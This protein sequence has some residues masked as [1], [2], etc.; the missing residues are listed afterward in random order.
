MDNAFQG[1]GQDRERTEEDL[2]GGPVSRG[3][4]NQSVSSNQAVDPTSTSSGD[5]AE[6]Y[7]RLINRDPSGTER[8]GSATSNRDLGSVGGGSIPG[9]NAYDGMNTSSSTAEGGSSSASAGSDRGNVPGM[10]ESPGASN[11]SGQPYQGTLGGRNPG[12]T[13]NQPIGDQDTTFGHRDA[14]EA[15][16]G[17]P[18]TSRAP[19]KVNQP[20]KQDDDS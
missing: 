20:P 14:K 16:I 13:Q 17:D 19:D 1:S 18:M 6:Q 3:A 4:S 8:G 7:N 2:A 12:Q 11:A 15:E 9:G 5:N 10:Q